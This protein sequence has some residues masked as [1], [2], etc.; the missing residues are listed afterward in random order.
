MKL[1]Y[2]VKMYKRHPVTKLAQADL[3][4]VHPLGKVLFA[5]P[6]F[7]SLS[8]RA[9]SSLLLLTS[10][11]YIQSPV[12]TIEENGEKITLA[13]SGAI[14]EYILERFASSTTS[15]KEMFIPATGSSAKDRANYLY[16]L[17]WAEGRLFF[18]Y[19]IRSR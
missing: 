1:D 15:G 19:F 5:S 3:K 11:Y 7:Y 18:I 10:F 13:E 14:V 9:Y 2:E 8:S 6:F 16:W 4:E 12:V 17:H